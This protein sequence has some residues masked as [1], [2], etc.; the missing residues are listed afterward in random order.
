MDHVFN[1]P[2]GRWQAVLDTA[3]ATGLPMQRGEAER[4]FA[5]RARSMVLLIT[6][7]LRAGARA[8]T[9]RPSAR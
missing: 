8:V 2:V 9:S 4:E 7:R 1:L 5:L 3:E 6:V